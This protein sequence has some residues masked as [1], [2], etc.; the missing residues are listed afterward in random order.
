GEGPLTTC[1]CLKG[2]TMRRLFTLEYWR[3]G[4][5]YVGRLMEVPGMD[6]GAIHVSQ[7][8]ESG[9]LRPLPLAFQGAQ[10]LAASQRWGIR[11]GQALKIGK[12]Q[13]SEVF[14][15]VSARP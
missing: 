6:I 10:R 7:A 12:D 9:R 8:P 5:W 14:V 15:G 2:V 1:L 13:G 3:D 11:F 4:E